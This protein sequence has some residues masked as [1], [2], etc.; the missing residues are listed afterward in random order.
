[1]EEKELRMIW[2]SM[3]WNKC[4]KSL[5]L[6]SVW[7]TVA[8]VMKENSSLT[9]LNVRN[10]IG[11]SD[12]RLLSDSLC[13]NQ[14]IAHLSF[15]YRLEDGTAEI[16]EELLEKNRSIK[17]L[18]VRVGFDSRTLKFNQTL[19]K[20]DL[21]LSHLGAE[22][23][24]SIAE[25]LASNKSMTELNLCD[26]YIFQAGGAIL[27]DAL[28]INST[29][30]VLNLNRSR[31]KPEDGCAIGDMLKHNRSLISLDVSH[32][33]LNLDS[34]A[35]GLEVNQVL[36]KLVATNVSSGVGQFLEIVL[37]RNTS[38]TEIDV[39]CNKAGIDGDRLIGEG[40]KVNKT[41]QKLHL[42][43]VTF[44]RIQGIAQ[45]L[46]SNT[47]LKFLS[48]SLGSEDAQAMCEALAVNRTLDALVMHSNNFGDL[49]AARMIK[50]NKTLR[51]LDVRY[52]HAIL[53]SLETNPS[54]ETLLLGEISSAQVI[55][56][57]IE[58]T[59]SLTQIDVS[60]TNLDSYSQMI[61]EAISTSQSIV[62][63]NVWTCGLE[64]EHIL[65]ALLRNRN[66]IAVD[67]FN[68]FRISALC[69]RNKHLRQHRVESSVVTLIALKMRLSA[70]PK[71]VFVMIAKH[72]FETHEDM[73]AWR[74]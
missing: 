21:S 43:D 9:E 36:Q 20:L 13:I 54:L 15:Q 63:Y 58:K 8:E 53:K 2:D 30:T 68:D 1:M 70:V 44:G 16:L 4:V 49:D 32:N 12:F 41:L 59:K 26:C 57:L 39:S 62:A 5:A 17:S 14:S 37:G 22:G 35:K 60:G 40:I 19:T 48:V 33:D 74:V 72:L 64:T 42:R 28:K 51:Y 69:R 56:N 10:Y 29:L 52:N 45:G 38:L 61:A 46:R 55:C 50:C 73:R 27:S 7:P 18:S 67:G 66:V 25:W 71:E 31:L 34:L 23:L 65:S 47:T 24:K 11:P 6:T 3:K